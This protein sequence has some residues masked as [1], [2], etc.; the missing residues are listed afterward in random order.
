MSYYNIKFT[1]NATILTIYKTT[2][3]LQNCRWFRLNMSWCYKFDPS[4]TSIEKELNVN[5]SCTGL[6]CLFMLPEDKVTYSFLE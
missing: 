6:V 3:K 1:I 2:V 5:I 4:T